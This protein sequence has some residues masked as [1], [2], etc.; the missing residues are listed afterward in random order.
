[1]NSSITGQ[2]GM[3]YFVTEVGAKGAGETYTI[4]MDY[5]KSND[6]L[7]ADQ[8]EV[9]P[10]AN[11]ELSGETDWLSYLPWVLGLLGITLIAAGGFWYWRH[12]KIEEVGTQRRRRRR[13]VPSEIGT[14]TFEK[15]VYCHHCGKRAGSND[16]FCRFCGT[17][18][19]TE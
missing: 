10:S 9:Q 4:A 1:M 15:G 6:I 13:A 18:L 14:S 12:S 2:D 8:F 17:R 7:S 5:T 16:K 11:L 3:V 19:R